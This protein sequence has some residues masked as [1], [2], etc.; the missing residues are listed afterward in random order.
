MTAAAWFDQPQ[1][2]D[3]ILLLSMG[4]ESEH[5]ASFKQVYKVLTNR[6]VRVFSL[7]LGTRVEGTISGPIVK[8]SSA[9]LEV[10]MEPSYSPNREDDSN[11]SWGSGGYSVQVDIVG[12][13]QWEQQLTDKKLEALK[14]AAS[15]MQSA[16]TE[17]YLLTLS[18]SP[19]QLTLSLAADLKNKVPKAVVIYP[20]QLPACSEAKTP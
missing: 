19:A 13:G 6:E 15:R 20:R 16:M 8:M 1:P 5:H 9:G 18:S 4:L 17:Y 14:T 2:G 3:A 11:L 7:L 12:G 10:L